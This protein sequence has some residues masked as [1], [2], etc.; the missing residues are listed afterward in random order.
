ME[1]YW[2]YLRIAPTSIYQELYTATSSAKEMTYLSWRK[3]YHET[4][5]VATG[6]PDEPGEHT[7]RDRLP[8]IDSR[9]GR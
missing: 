4:M 2:N 5:N 6:R 3:D 8:T 9:G 1:L 7:R